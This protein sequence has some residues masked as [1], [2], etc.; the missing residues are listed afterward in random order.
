[1][2][3]RIIEIGPDVKPENWAAFYTD[4]IKSLQPGV[5]EIVVH[6]AYDN[7]EMRAATDGHPDWGAAWRQREFDFF[8][9]AAFR[10]L[11]KEQ[12]VKLVKWRDVM[13]G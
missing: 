9:S 7:D 13:K 4:A 5:T 2:L 10:Q 6:I 1:M 3:D 11:L 8:T 12:N